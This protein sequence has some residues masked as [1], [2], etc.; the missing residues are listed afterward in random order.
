MQLNEF[1]K[2]FKRPALAFSGGVDSSY[3]L[4]AAKQANCDINA[5]FFKTPFQ[6]QFELEDAQ[7]LAE[8]I[9][10]HLEI[11]EYDVLQ[12]NDVVE[13][14]SNRCY[15]CKKTLF[16]KLL[17][18]AKEAGCDVIF[19]GTNA[20]DDINDRPGMRAISELGVRSPLRECNLTKAEIR[21][22]SKE[23]G[24]FTYNKPSYSCLAT[25]IP[26]GT[27]LTFELLK[28]VERS[29]KSLFKMG[30]S[31]FRIRVVGNSAKIQLKTEQMPL[32]LT[33]RVKI[34]DILSIDFE[35]ILLDLKAR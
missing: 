31:D 16:T 29:E 22:L 15:Y 9:G 28:K 11:V 5:W 17:E 24:L 25:R 12:N 20:S 7:R 10:I 2:Q 33:K 14:P 3:L 23:A 30:F 18:K 26:T 6:P 21:K 8:E 13:N 19:D 34:I 35:D 1:F 32:L 27:K 4:W